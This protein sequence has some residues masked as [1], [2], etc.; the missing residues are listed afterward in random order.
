MNKKNVITGVISLIIALV[1]VFFQLKKLNIEEVKA[2]IDIVDV[3]GD[4]V[5]LKK[6]GTNYKAL[7]P[8]TSEKT[9]SFFVSPAKGAVHI[10]M[11]MTATLLCWIGS[12]SSIPRVRTS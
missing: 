5:N 6:A 3:I 2:M 4:Y 10:I 7:S 11:M 9:P 8:F 1:F 12:S